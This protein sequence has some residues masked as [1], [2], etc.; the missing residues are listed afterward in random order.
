[1]HI[2]FACD[3][4]YES[5]RD[6]LFFLFSMSTPIFFTEYFEFI[7]ITSDLERNFNPV[8]L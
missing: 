6:Q 4:I 8:R 2:E 5:K 7:Q 3:A 1:M